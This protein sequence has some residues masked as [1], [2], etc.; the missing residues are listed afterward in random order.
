ML[1]CL[2]RNVV[3][4]KSRIRIGTL[5]SRPRR[6]MR[7][8][9]ASLGLMNLKL[10]ASAITSRMPERKPHAYKPAEAAGNHS[11]GRFQHDFSNPLLGL[12][13]PLLEKSNLAFGKDDLQKLDHGMNF[14][15]YI[16]IA[17]YINI[18][19]F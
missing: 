18:S 5:G 7:Y 3:V 15:M 19:R 6:Y 10:I 1:H 14:D 9:G 17:T 13:I 4:A 12:D 11:K 2:R 8:P 16:Y